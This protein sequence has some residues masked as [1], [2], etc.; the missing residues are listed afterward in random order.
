MAH[1]AKLD[2]NDIVE[3]VSE[4]KFIWLGRFDNVVNSG[5]IKLIPEQIEEKLATRIARRY[6]VIGQPDQVLGEKLVLIV[7]GEPFTIEEDVF[8]VLDKYE[9]PKEIHFV[10]HFEET[11]T[12]KI[13][14]KETLSKF[15]F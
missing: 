1:F 5:G 12:G 11:P 7:E 9:K 10:K 14:R 8:D 6:F 4:N 15:M 13:I 2:E 3:M